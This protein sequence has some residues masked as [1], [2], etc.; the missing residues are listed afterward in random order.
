MIE[1]G[2]RRRHVVQQAAASGSL[3]ASELAVGLLCARALG[4]EGLGKFAAATAL[5]TVVFAVFDLRLQEATVVLGTA[6]ESGR[7]V[8]DRAAVLRRL[9]VLDVASGVLG[10]IAVAAIAAAAPAL[11]SAL[12]MAPGLVLCAG[13]AI[14]AKN[15]GNAVSRA[16]LRITDRYGMLAVLTC[17]GAIVRVSAVTPAL[18]GSVPP[19]PERMLLLVLAGNAAAGAL[20]VLPTVLVAIGRDGITVGGSPATPESATR[21]RSFVRGSWLQS[22]ALAPLREMDVVVLAALAGDAAVG[23][24]RLA[25]T[26]IQGIDA[27]LSPIHLVVFPHVARLLAQGETGR[28]ATF[29]RRLTGRLACGATAVAIVG[30][31]TAPVMVEALAGPTFAASVPL[32]QAI[33]ALMPLVAAGIWVG[34]LLVAAGATHRAA[35]VTAVAGAASVAVTAALSAAA[36]AWGPVAGYAAFVTIAT[37]T[38]LLAARRDPTLGPIVGA[39][40]RTAN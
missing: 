12:S 9:L 5:A 24:Y 39:V 31:A 6:L 17:A 15:A 36:G 21:M 8:S 4:A 38:S 13:A 29:L 40:V 26:G 11:P 16:Y 19:D 37:V 22:L 35:A 10:F 28:L 25:R 3:A 27:L 33:L 30:I 34:P 2:I 1:R 18:T 20:L 7:G 23:T 14:L 32:L